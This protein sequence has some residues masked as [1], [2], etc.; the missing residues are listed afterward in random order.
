MLS[1]KEMEEREMEIQ[2]VPLPNTIRAGS[3][4]AELNMI[5]E[6]MVAVITLGHEVL[7]S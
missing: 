6:T 4:I 7:V 3:E 5:D 1:Q 2:S